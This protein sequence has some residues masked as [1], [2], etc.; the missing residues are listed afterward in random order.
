MADISLPDVALR[1]NTSQRL[2]CVLLLDGSGSMADSAAIDELNAGVRLLEDELKKDDVA[3]QR[4]Q[5]LVIRFGGDTDVEVV[6]DWTDAMSFTAPQLT[7]SGLTPMGEAVRVGLAKLEEQKAR[8]RA[9][10]IAYN[11][12]WMFVITD[13]EP[14]DD[15]WKQAAV[16]CKAAEQANKLIF[17]GI[18]VG[19][20]ADLTKLAEF[21]A[22]KPVRLQGLKFREL[23]HWL[24]SSAKSAS[25]QAPGSNVQLAPPSDWM[26][27]SA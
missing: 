6:A 4:V 17:F 8:Y 10:G 27:V 20:G 23:F 26:Q 19:G 9:N 2:P 5:L 24:S 25:K 11:R 13:G 21:S 18:G 14:T 1:D 3:S 7:A 12:P 16:Q 22:R 15:D